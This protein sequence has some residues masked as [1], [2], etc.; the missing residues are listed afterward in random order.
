MKAA[1]SSPPA[2]I[3]IAPPQQHWQ[4]TNAT[5]S[6][7][8]PTS[9]GPTLGTFPSANIMTALASHGRT[10]AALL[11]AANNGYRH[12][13][14]PSTDASSV[15]ANLFKANSVAVS[16]TTVP[17][18]SRLSASVVPALPNPLLLHHNTVHHTPNDRTLFLPT[19]R[20]IVIQ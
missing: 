11:T 8:S 4:P 7:P 5:T 6:W 16:P 12:S 19:Q 17:L 18:S 3:P 14:F 13:W 2:L 15:A 10:T 9:S 1:I 20:S